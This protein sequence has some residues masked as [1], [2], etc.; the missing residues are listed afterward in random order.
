MEMRGLS[1]NRFDKGDLA[2]R[3]VERNHWRRRNGATDFA[4]VVR[5]QDGRG[6]VGI[7][8]SGGH[9]SRVADSSAACRAAIQ[10]VKGHKIRLSRAA[11]SIHRE[12]D[13]IVG[14]TWRGVDI[15]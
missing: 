13:E 2:A 5:E 3:C 9:G 1:R 6:R 8:F 4:D 10:V 14:T 11:R 15:E 12:N 7:G